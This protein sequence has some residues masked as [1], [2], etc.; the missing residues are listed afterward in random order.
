MR[1]RTRTVVRQSVT[2][3][4]T[5][6][7]IAHRCNGTLP[8]AT[9]PAQGVINIDYTDE[10]MRDELGK[11]SRHPVIHRSR[12]VSLLSQPIGKYVWYDNGTGYCE[13]NA[14][15]PHWAYAYKNDI[16]Q[17]P[18]SFDINSLT[19]SNPI[20][21]TINVPTFPNET[22]LKEDVLEKAKQLK[23][24]ILLDLIEAHQMASFVVPFAQ[25]LPNYRIDWRTL[26]KNPRLTKRF[27]LRE[28]KGIARSISGNHLM[29]AFG[30][31]P[32]VSDLI[33]VNKALAT[34]ARDVRRFVDQEE[35]RYSS[36]AETKASFIGVPGT[37][38]SV[39]N[40]GVC[41]SWVPS[42]KVLS[43]PTTRYVLVVRPK[44]QL[45]EDILNK[46]DFLMSRFG[47]SP[48][49][50]AWELV[51]FSFVVDWFVDLRG[52]LRLL[53]TAVGYSP[54]DIVGF[55]RSYSYH[56]QDSITMARKNPCNGS[57]VAQYVPGTVEYK[58]YER[59]LV[60]DRSY[61]PVW[62]PR[63]GNNQLAISASLITQMLLKRI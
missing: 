19:R 15:S 44:K 20:W 3:S 56:V 41:L 9:A 45:L 16:D 30:I 46:I 23:A 49:S 5:E 11:G 12:K 8:S 53:D 32:L 39:G 28:V 14:V 59:S 4:A 48:A 10:T 63:I 13:T 42:G 47:S 61:W 24:D 31:A 2:L 18:S 26:R 33:A 25:A 7:S 6:A 38:T 29:Y 34:M 27:A 22:S 55:T 35:M 1:L 57:I 58:H 17:G 50:L 54:Y 60:S 52:I 43:P 40:T 37:W 51:P 36:K 62:K 21:W